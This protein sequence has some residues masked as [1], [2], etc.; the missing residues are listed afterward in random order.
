M[1]EIL[2]VLGVAVAI[3]YVLITES[4]D[5]IGR[6]EYLNTHHPKIARFL[7][8]GAERRWL[9][10]ILLLIAIILLSKN[11][12]VMREKHPDSQRQC[13]HS[14]RWVAN[15]E[16][17][18]AKGASWADEVIVVCNYDV[19]QP[20]SWELEFDQPLIGAYAQIIGDSFYVGGATIDGNKLV[21]GVSNDL[22]AGRVLTL[23]AYT[24]ERP[25]LTHFTF[26]SP[27]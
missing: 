10:L 13:W 24:K 5:W 6:I 27:P 1:E 12:D 15:T 20:L 9:R 18:K 11:I 26:G 25:R 4:A 17:M 19:D 21:G 22:R 3:V 23:T 2:T 14:A 8:R 7:H 16:Q